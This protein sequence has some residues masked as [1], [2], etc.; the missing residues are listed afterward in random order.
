MKAEEQ[1]FKIKVWLATLLKE[2]GRGEDEVVRLKQLDRME[3]VIH[4]M[5]EKVR[6]A[7]TEAS[8][9]ASNSNAS[10]SK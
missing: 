7:L 6:L 10:T 5:C 9:L 4:F 3:E 8:N 1:L 2:V